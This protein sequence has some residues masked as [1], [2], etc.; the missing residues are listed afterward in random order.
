MIDNIEVSELHRCPKCGIK[1]LHA[2]LTSPITYY[3]TI[4]DV[5]WSY[6]L[7]IKDKGKQVEDI[8]AWLCELREAIDHTGS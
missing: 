8:A 6:T 4:C 3:C 1:G 7:Q 2:H 5:E